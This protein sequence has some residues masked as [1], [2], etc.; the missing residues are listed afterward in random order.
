V[1]ELLAQVEM[2]ELTPTVLVRALDAWPFTI[3]TLDGLH[4]ATIEYLRA[5][6]TAIQLASYDLRLLNAA[7]ALQIPMYAL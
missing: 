4:L 3:R 5:G 7:R 1:R 6:G 2:V